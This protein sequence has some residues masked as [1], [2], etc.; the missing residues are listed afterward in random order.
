MLRVLLK[1]GRHDFSPQGVYNQVRDKHRNV[2][3]TR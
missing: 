1:M 3:E 2:C